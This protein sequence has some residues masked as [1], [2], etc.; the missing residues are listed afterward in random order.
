MMSLAAFGLFALAMTLGPQHDAPVWAS[1][2]S[3]LGARES[4]LR[5]DLFMLRSLIS[6][7]TLDKQKAPESLQELV[8]VGYLKQIPIDPMTSKADWDVDVI[9]DPV[10]HEPGISSVRSSSQKVSSGGTVYNSW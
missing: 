6:Q 1:R 4:V 3:V 7:Y 10:C 9:M 2:D 8:K 5:Q